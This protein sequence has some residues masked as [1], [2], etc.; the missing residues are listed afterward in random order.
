MLA[1]M[2]HPDPFLPFGSITLHRGECVERYVGRIVY[3]ER[4]VR[5]FWLDSDIGPGDEQ[6]LERVTDICE[7]H[8]IAWMT[9]AQHEAHLLTVRETAAKNVE[10]LAR[11]ERWPDGYEPARRRFEHERLRD[12]FRRL[13]D[14]AVCGWYSTVQGAQEAAWDDADGAL[15]EWTDHRAGALDGGEALPLERDGSIADVCR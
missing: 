5:V 7:P 10:H 14:G 8:T 11:L 13:R 2:L 15:G 3:V 9:E 6:A 1:P 4:G 12:G